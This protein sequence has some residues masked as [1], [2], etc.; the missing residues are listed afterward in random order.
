MAKQDPEH[1]SRRFQI[2]LVGAFA[3]ALAVYF[4]GLGRPVAPDRT[5]ST[6]QTSEAPYD[7]PVYSEMAT[8]RR[9]EEMP[10]LLDRSP[11]QTNDQESAENGAEDVDIELARLE[12]AERRAFDGA[13]PTIPH[14]IGESTVICVDCH[15][16][17][18]T[19]GDLVVPAMSHQ[20]LGSCTQCHVRAEID[21]PWSGTEMIAASLFEGVDSAED[22]GDIEAT[23]AL[24][25]PTIPHTTWM[26]SNCDSCHGSTGHQ[27]LRSPHPDRVSCTQCHIPSAALEQRAS[28]IVPFPRDEE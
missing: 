25:P 22:R 28:A 7:A 23:W 18:M 27:A 10:S 9:P 11:Q 17:G 19:L 3:L 24:A 16:G 2:V 8:F 12:R 4:L 13:P 20:D 15:R 6:A 1:H 5:A 14:P 21:R 26:R